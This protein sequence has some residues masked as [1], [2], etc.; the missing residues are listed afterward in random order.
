MKV[1]KLLTTMKKVKLKVKEYDRGYIKDVSRKFNLSKISSRILLNRNITEY[2]EIEEF[3]NPDF[4]YFE[5]AKNYKDLQRGCSRVLE[6]IDKNQKI[7]IYGDYDVDG[8]TS[9][10]QFILLLSKAGADVDYYVPE[11]ENEGYGIS[12]EFV[13]KLKDNRI[14]ADLVVTVDCGIAEIE[15]IACISEMNKDVVIIDHHQCKEELPP[16]YAVID[17]KQK[18]CPSKNKHLCAA[19]LSFKFL[20]HLNTYLKVE[21]IEDVLLELACLGTIADI[22]DLFGDNRVIAKNGLRKINNTRLI[23]LKKLIEVSGIKDKEIESYHIGFIIAPRINAAG[24]M[25]T[26]KKAIKLM[27][28]SDEQEAEK[29]ALEL[30]ALNALRKQAESVIFEEAVNKIETDFLYKK[31]IIVVY[32]ENWHEGVLGIV[33]SK[34]T[35]KYEIPSVVISMKEGIGK[36]SARSLECVDIFEA[37]TAVKQYLLK[38]GGHKLAAGL[39]IEEKNINIFAD[40]LNSYIFSLNRDDSLNEIEADSYIEAKDV[41]F[42]LYK[43]ICMFE[44]YGSGNPKPVFALKDAELKNIRKVGRDGSHLS[45]VLVK[46]NREISVIGF[47]K[48]GILEKVLTKPSAYVVTMSLNEFNGRKSIQLVLQNVEDSDKLDYS[49]DDEKMKVLNSVINK[50]KSK[51]IKTDIFVLVEKLNKIYNTKITAEEIICMLKK[52]D[53]IQYALKNEVLYI[54]K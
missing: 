47:G 42:D 44:P 2:N 22:V 34:L 25:D 4:K 20:K 45:F 15:K 43:E 54:K 39:T 14:E 19:G 40:E 30:E 9:I 52:A 6:A 50:S 10:S 26:A 3:L 51:I 32:G 38:Y 24:R 41:S 23:G 7:I 1:P 36:G 11:R 17:P 33:A 27:L 12:S 35:D 29:L 31:S 49:I 5:N 28:S 13:E 21:D 53:N 18:D 46:D 16:A 37:F 48:I 8:V